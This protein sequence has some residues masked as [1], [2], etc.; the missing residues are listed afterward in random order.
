MSSETR[1]MKT[2]NKKKEG[3]GWMEWIRGWA[4]VFHEFLFQRFMSSHLP[5]PLPLP[6]L[7]HLT[8][9]VT[10]ST[11][12]I[13]RETARQLAEAGAHV[14]MAARDTKAA[15]DLIQ[16][17]QRDWS[18][19]GLPLN[20]EAMELDLLSLDSVVKFSNAWNARLA[21]LHV[22][23]NNAGIFAMGAVL[24]FQLSIVI[25]FEVSKPYCSII[26]HPF[27]TTQVDFDISITFA[28][29]L[30]LSMIF[31]QLAEA[32]AHVV[33]AVRNMKAANALIQQ[34]RTKWSASGTGHPLNVTIDQLYSTYT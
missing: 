27:N 32:G 16:Q 10:G 23:I 9:I 29:F 6:P 8:C 15:H 31:R 33:M 1:R 12:G 11:S 7:S 20:I 21:P 3:L 22:L 2:K 28:S 17:W 4:C 25:V 26:H 30:A 24:H 13:G 14:V 5:N 18:A 34:W 19:K